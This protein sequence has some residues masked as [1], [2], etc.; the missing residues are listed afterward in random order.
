MLFCCE[1]HPLRSYSK[2]G[3]HKNAHQRYNEHEIVEN[4]IKKGIDSQFGDGHDISNRGEIQLPGAD[5]LR[6][7]NDESKSEGAKETRFRGPDLHSDNSM[8]LFL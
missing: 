1:C 8:N 6:T 4:E 7:S 5:H 2:K 3:R